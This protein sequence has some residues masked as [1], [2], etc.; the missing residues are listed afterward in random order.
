MQKTLSH[1][2]LFER[3]IHTESVKKMDKSAVI[4]PPHYSEFLSLLL[5]IH[6]MYS[7]L[8]AIA[9]VAPTEACDTV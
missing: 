3:I 1:I 7:I 5:I 2:H 4:I 8:L 9:K 6:L